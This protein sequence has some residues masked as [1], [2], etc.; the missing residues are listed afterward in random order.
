M[1]QVPEFQLCNHRTCVLKPGNILSCLNLR[2]LSKTEV[3]T[4]Y[5]VV[6]ETMKQK[7]LKCLAQRI[8]SVKFSMFLLFPHCI[9]LIKVV[10]FTIQEQLSHRFRWSILMK[11][12]WYFSH[13]R[14]R[15]DKE[16]VSKAPH[17]SNSELRPSFLTVPLPGIIP[18]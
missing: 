8:N 13:T 17:T 7:Y 2:S 10:A 18:F 11:M 5:Y 1:D 15:Q 6:D 12:L 16:T 4:P 3:I 14:R 9:S